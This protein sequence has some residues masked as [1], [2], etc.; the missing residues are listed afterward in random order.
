MNCLWLAA[1]H[2]VSSDNIVCYVVMGGMYQ[3]SVYFCYRKQ[4]TLWAIGD[5]ERARERSREIAKHQYIRMDK[6]DKFDKQEKM[7]KEETF[8]LSEQECPPPYG[9]FPTQGDRLNLLKQQRIY[10]HHKLVSS[11]CI[12]YVYNTISCVDN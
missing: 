5:M 10:P 12:R 2:A 11:T 6:E 1:R 4:A 8:V 7:D 9:N 3:M